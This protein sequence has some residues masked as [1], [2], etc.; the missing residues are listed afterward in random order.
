M[1]RNSFKIIRIGL[2]LVFLANGLTAFFSPQE[3]KELLEASFVSQILPL[4]ITAFLLIIGINDLLMSGLILLNRYQKYTF[5]WA[6]LWLIGVM[7]V[8]ARPLDILEHLGFFSMALALWIE[9][10]SNKSM[11]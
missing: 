9:A 3:L 8:V 7:I 2:A 10:G 6:M 1:N 4:P 11:I 5:G